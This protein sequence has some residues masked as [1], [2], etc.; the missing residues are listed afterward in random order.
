MQS[1]TGVFV[2]GFFEFGA[3]VGNEIIAIIKLLTRGVVSALDPLYFGCRG[4]W[5]E[6]GQFQVGAEL[7]KFIHELGPAVYLNRFDLLRGLSTGWTRNRAVGIGKNI[8]I[9][10]FVS[11]VTSLEMMELR[12][13]L[14]VII[15]FVFILSPIIMSFLSRNHRFF[16][17]WQSAACA[18]LAGLKDVFGRV[19]Y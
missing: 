14:V 10:E 18:W 5:N 1:G 12:P 19:L 16:H 3:G 7:S 4:R 15:W 17:V 9:D 2:D 6:D 13:F 11:P 8:G